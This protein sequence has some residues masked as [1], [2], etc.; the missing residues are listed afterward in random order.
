M[1]IIDAISKINDLKHN[2]FSQADKVEWLSRLDSMVKK[3]IIDTH[4]GG[5][6]VTF[7]GYTASTNPETEMLIPEPY[8]EAYLRWLEAQI[9][10]HN[11]EIKKYNNSMSMF[12]TVWEGFKNHYK[13]TH[14]PLSRGNRFIF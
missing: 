2:T 4:Q 11:D 12:Y 8:D 9:D 14:M 10:Y 13:L 1:K 5:E 6:G 7:T 3:L